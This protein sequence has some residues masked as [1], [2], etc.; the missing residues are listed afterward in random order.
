MARILIAEDDP[1][2]FS[3]IEK[4]L[5]KAGYSTQVA[6]DG[7]KAVEFALSGDFDL[8]LLDMALPSRDGFEVLQE[9][10][11]GGSQIPVIVVT[12]RPEMREHVA[13]LSVGSADFM[14]KPFRFE[15]LLAR[16]RAHLRFPGMRPHSDV[17]VPT[18]DEERSRI[19]VDPPSENG[20]RGAG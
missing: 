5:R 3:F 14:I 20:Q 4:R 1:L 6:D 7:D 12:G 18:H 10:R 15:E 9:L 8:V 11:R 19:S 2:V 13:H 17:E 16:V